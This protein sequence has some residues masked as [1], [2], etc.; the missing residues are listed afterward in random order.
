VAINSIKLGEDVFSYVSLTKKGVDHDIVPVIS[1]ISDMSYSPE[2]AAK[3]AVTNDKGLS[4]LID[5]G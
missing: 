4:W 3:E 2:K 1:G 5:F